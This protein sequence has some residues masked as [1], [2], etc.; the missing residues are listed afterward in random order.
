MTI[1]RRLG[2]NV[3]DLVLFGIFLVADNQLHVNIHDKKYSNLTFA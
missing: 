3:E 1:V 2:N